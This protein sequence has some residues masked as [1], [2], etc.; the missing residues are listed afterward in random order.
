[1]C[2]SGYAPRLVLTFEYT[3]INHGCVTIVFM[4]EIRAF[5]VR[6]VTTSS[7]KH[8]QL[9]HYKRCRSC[10]GTKLSTVRCTIFSAVIGI[11][12]IG[13]VAESS[14]SISGLYLC[15]TVQGNPD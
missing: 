3:M 2:R 11:I 6:K 4:T 7:E 15:D 14:V 10:A 13:S 9:L 5:T 1:M 8:M 12:P